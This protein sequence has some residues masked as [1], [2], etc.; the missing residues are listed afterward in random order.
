MPAGLDA[1]LDEVAAL[2]G[3]EQQRLCLA[4]ALV[5]DPELLV[6]DEATSALDPDTERA[7]LARL[8]DGRR[9]ILMAAHRVPAGAG[10]VLRIDAGQITTL[11]AD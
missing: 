8:L 11:G 6:L 7:I 1:P 10:R 4:R 9:T 2:S 5:R 3:G